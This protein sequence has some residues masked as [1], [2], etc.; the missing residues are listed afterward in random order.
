MEGWWEV[1][2]T[3]GFELDQRS[4]TLDGLFE[5][6]PDFFFTYVKG[7]S[8][9][10]IEINTAPVDEFSHV[11]LMTD[12]VN[13]TVAWYE[14]L[15]DTNA[16]NEE[17][18]SALAGVWDGR[19]IRWSTNNLVI[20]RVNMIVFGPPF[21]FIPEEF[22]SSDDRAIGHIAFSFVDLEPV[23]ERIGAMSAEVVSALGR[24]PDHGFASMYVRGPNEVLV[25]LVQAGPIPNP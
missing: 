16:A 8:H 17:A 25:E 23:I 14:E 22:E 5:L 20:D 12:D 24:D 1:A 10:R 7:P 4:G 19:Q 6:F 13:T 21:P 2:R 15:L 18:S 3:Q 9:E 11:H